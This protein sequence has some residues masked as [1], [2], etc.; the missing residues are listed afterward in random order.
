MTDYLSMTFSVT[1]VYL[2]P[3]FCY[4]NLIVCSCFNRFGYALNCSRL[5]ADYPGNDGGYHMTDK[6]GM[7]KKGPTGK[8]LGLLGCSIPCKG[9]EKEWRMERIAIIRLS[10]LPAS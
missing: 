4:H 7:K 2:S 3:L 6:N 5:A 8:L 10:E 9:E 1:L